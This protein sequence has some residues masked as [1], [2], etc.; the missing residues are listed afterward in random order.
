MVRVLKTTTSTIYDW[1]TSTCP[2]CGGQA[3]CRNRNAGPHHSS[4]PKPTLASDQVPHNLQAL[5]AHAPGASWSQPCVPVGH[6]V[7]RRWPARSWETKIL[8][9]LPIWTSTVETKVRWAE[10]L[11]LGTEGMEFSSVQSSG[12]HKHWYLQK[13]FENSPF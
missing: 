1:S 9:Q 5:R 6:D 4:P 7:T 10:F 8:Q 12:T 2:E 13:T 11:I 3:C